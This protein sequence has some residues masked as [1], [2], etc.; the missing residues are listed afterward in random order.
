MIVVDTNI[1]AYFFIEGDKTKLARE[2]WKSDPDWA[3]PVLWRH[4][5]LNVLAVFAQHQGA[6]LRKILTLWAQAFQWL[7][8]GEREVNPD[9]ALKL[10]VNDGISAYDAQYIVL[11]KTLEVP[12]ITEDKKLLKT[13][14]KITLSMQAFLKE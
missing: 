6:S 11:A 7:A 10:A 8:E 4:E 3:L 1:I 12:C 14:P 5:Y 9:F 13:F 2:L